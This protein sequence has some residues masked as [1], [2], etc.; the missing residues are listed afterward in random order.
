MARIGI[1]ITTENTSIGVWESPTVTVT[2]IPANAEVGETIT[3]AVNVKRA[4][5]TTPVVGAKVNTFV[6]DSHG[7][8]ALGIGQDTDANGDITAPVDYHVS[9]EDQDS[10]VSFHIVVWPKSI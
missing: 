9:P 3:P 8:F 6:S 10:T 5:G 7:T 2:G 4:D 1:D